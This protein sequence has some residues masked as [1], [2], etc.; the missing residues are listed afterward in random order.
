MTKSELRTVTASIQARLAAIT[1]NAS[2]REE[3]VIQQAPDPFDEVQLNSERDL[4]IALL[5]HE[6]VLARN[7]KAALRRIE[8]GSYGLCAQCEEG[9]S[10]KRLAA[11]PW[12][13]RCIQCQE[14]A[15][16][17]RNK[18]AETAGD[19]VDAA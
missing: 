17:D 1:K 6:T 2:K 14:A 12:A 5:N 16:R 15:D 13:E 8:D 18:S 3:I 11:V 9:I 10:P 4:T 19:L 7:L